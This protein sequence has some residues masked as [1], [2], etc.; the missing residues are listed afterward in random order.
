MPAMAIGSPFKSSL[1]RQL[2]KVECCVPKNI[3]KEKI[4][5]RIALRLKPQKAFGGWFV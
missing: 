4:P 1:P 5:R 3:I 2:M